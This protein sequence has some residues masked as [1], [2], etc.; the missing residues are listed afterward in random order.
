M[1]TPDN[2]SRI[3]AARRRA[4]VAKVMVASSGALVFGA[5]LALA[6]ANQVGHVRR[7]ARPLQAPRSFRSSVRSD[8]LSAGVL[9]PQQAPPSAATVSS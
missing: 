8:Q 5:S 6:R 9:A 4:R 3:A 1:K 7:A 2:A